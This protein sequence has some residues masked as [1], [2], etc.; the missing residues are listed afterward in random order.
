MNYTQEY[1]KYLQHFVDNLKLKIILPKNIEEL[2]N[3]S[4]KLDNLIL[5][6]WSNI[7]SEYNSRSISIEKIEKEIKYNVTF[8][9]SITKKLSNDK[10]IK[11]APQNVIDIEYK[12]KSD[13]EEKINILE[14]Q[15]KEI[16]L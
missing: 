3:L 1:Q 6:I 4:E 13:T 10:F 8:L 12:K 5:K 2:D 16:K 9:D 7:E 14:K 11:N 15:L